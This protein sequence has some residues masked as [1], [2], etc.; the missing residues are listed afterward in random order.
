MNRL[1]FAPIRV[2]S[3]AGLFRL[4]RSFKFKFARGALGTPPAPPAV[5]RTEDARAFGAARAEPN[6]RRAPDGDAR[7][8]RGERAFARP[9]AR[10][11]RRVQ[12]TP[13]PPAVFRLDNEE[14]SPDGI[15]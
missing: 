6:V 14:T 7:A 12:F 13:R 1:C 4:S 2:I 15:A 10:H 11:S 3:W 8:A 5:R 9:R